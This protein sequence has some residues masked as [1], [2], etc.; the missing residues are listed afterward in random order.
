MIG[1][2]RHHRGPTWQ[3]CQ[4]CRSLFD[5]A[6]IGIPAKDESE[7]LPLVL[8]KLKRHDFKIMVVLHKSDLKT[9]N[10]IKPFKVKIVF[11]NNLGYG[12]ALI[13]GINNCKKIFDLK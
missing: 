8:K 2:T 3:S 11:Q 4:P 7:S 9:I 5:S 1:K 13:K 6:K 12:D 10:S